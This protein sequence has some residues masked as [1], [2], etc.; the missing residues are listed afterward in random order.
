MPVR[1][2][3]MASGLDT[4]TLIKGMMDAHKL[5]NK[6]VSDKSQILEWKQERLKEVNAKLY[7]LYAEDLTKLKMQSAYNT[8]K[9][10]SSN[11]NVV[12]VT[13]NSSAPTGTAAITVDQLA[14][15]QSIIGQPLGKDVN[16][17]DV[18]SST[19]L[20]DLGFV[21]K[22]QITFKTKNGEKVLDVNSSTTI[23]DFIQ[24]AK[25]AGINANFDTAQKRIFL[26]AS[27]SGEDNWFSVTTSTNDKTDPKRSMDDAVGYSQLSTVNKAKV[28][29][30][31]KLIEGVDKA[32]LENIFGNTTIDEANDSTETRTLKLAV[33][34]VLELMDTNYKTKYEAEANTIA[35]NNTG[36]AILDAIKN[37]GT[38]AGVDYQGEYKKFED[39][40]QAAMEA[41]YG[42]T[43]NLTEEKYVK[44]K[45]ALIESYLNKRV[46]EELKKEEVTNIVNTEKTRII[47]EGTSIVDS[48]GSTTI[49]P[50]V[51]DRIAEKIG[52]FKTSATSYVDATGESDV[53][54]VLNKL[55]LADIIAKDVDGKKIIEIENG[56]VI[57]EKAQNSKINYNGLD[58][59]SDTNVVSVNGLT[60]T[61]KG[62]TPKNEVTSTNPDGTTNTT[63]TKEPITLSTI[64]DTQATVDSVKKFIT[65]Y[66]AILKEMNELYYAGSARDYAP[67]SDDERESMTDSQIEKWEKKIKDSMLRR[68]SNISNVLTGMKQAVMTT[69]KAS[70]G[71]TYSL[72]SLGIGTSSDYTEKGLLHLDGN[73]DETAYSMKTNKLMNMLESD[74]DIVA[75][76]LSKTMDTLYKDIDSK[77]K[78][79]PN[80]RSAFTFYN[81]KTMNTQQTT[82]KK[83]IS[84]LE[85]K[86]T[87]VEAKYY[88]QFAAME[89][90]MANLQSQSNALTGMLGGSSK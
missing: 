38:Y 67:L 27:K 20:V 18:T 83:K 55:G 30:L 66:N 68:D 8:K 48:D 49:I 11:E 39:D 53:S 86:L 25:E 52:A 50:K 82:Y 34:D 14:K 3:G 40:A 51:V 26:S 24:K 46:N 78:A 19:T 10:S 88:K 90:A 36:K 1:M 87:T 58:I 71:K 65:N 28:D 6:K 59:E 29:K 63:I 21:D 7:K 41:K 22:T 61:L 13:G 72:A 56:T 62:V 75:E 4:E 79:I 43:V 44:E 23:S 70:D 77:I 74:P 42:N 81:D 80:V 35:V 54:N 45:E 73:P 37:G 69:V 15:A 16:K 31:Y 33:K 17:K 5:K 47:D 76:I 12:S 2:T 32:T 57:N 64:N 84:E 60:I 85:K 9:V 89:K